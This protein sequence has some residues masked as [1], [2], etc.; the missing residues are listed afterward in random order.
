MSLR[1]VTTAVAAALLFLIAPAASAHILE[2]DGSISAIMHIDPDDNPVVGQAATFSLQFR[3]Q[4][5][6]FNIT[7]CDCSAVITK[8]RQQVFSTS[9]TNNTFRYTFPERA[10]YALQVSGRPKQSGAF[11]SFHLAYDLRVARGI[12]PLGQEIQSDEHDHDGEGLF[13]EHTLHIVLFGVGF[14]VIGVLYLK[15]KY[16]ARK[17]KH[18][19]V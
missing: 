19:D 2:S 11:Q 12:T 5:N 15:D 16:K 1:I 9:L 10:I 13:A 8:N 3:D 4:D 7:A 17:L 18:P 14:L 6:R